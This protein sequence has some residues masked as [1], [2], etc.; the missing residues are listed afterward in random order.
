MRFNIVKGIFIIVVIGIIVFAIYSIY[1]QE[2]QE[3]TQVQNEQQAEVIEEKKDIRL[4]ISNFDTINPLLTTNKEVLNIGKLIF[5]PLLTLDENYKI[6]LCLATEW[7]KTSDTS[8]VVKIDNSVQWQDGS[9]LIAK[10]I[11]FTIDRLKEGKSIYS[12]N[13]EKVSSVEVIDAST[14]KINLSEPVPFLNII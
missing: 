7:S 1:F 2:D 5:E 4:G 8:Y 13:V 3:N 10:D 6:Q 14:V 11:Q 12:A 9:P